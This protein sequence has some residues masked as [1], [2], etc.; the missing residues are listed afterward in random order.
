MRNASQSVPVNFSSP[1]SDLEQEKLTNSSSEMIMKSYRQQIENL[2]R[3]LRITTDMC[4]E[5]EVEYKNAIKET[6]LNFHRALSQRD[7][8]IRLR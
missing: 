5:Q 7:D 6:E 1:T 2:Q 8:F 3:K 4:T